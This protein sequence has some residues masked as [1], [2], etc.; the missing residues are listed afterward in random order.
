MA[1]QN[2]DLRA[3]PRMPDARGLVVRRGDN[4][5]AIAAEPRAR[6]PVSMAFR[7]TI[8]V[9]LT[10][11]PTRVLKMLRD[12]RAARTETRLRG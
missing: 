1:F 11:S 5:R 8:S 2:D 9:P 3:V 10:V 12:S 4:P 6:H 7:T